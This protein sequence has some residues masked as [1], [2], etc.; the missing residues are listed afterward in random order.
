MACHKVQYLD[1]HF[2]YKYINDLCNVYS[3]L[4][5]ILF[6]DDTNIFYSADSDTINKTI[7][8]YLE[9]EGLLHILQ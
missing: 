5:F 8:W 4:K 7:T 9:K 3:I 2:F 1:R 6:A